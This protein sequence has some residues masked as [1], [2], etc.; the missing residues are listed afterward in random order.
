MN[1]GACEL[2]SGAHG[3]GRS[4][5]RLEGAQDSC[6]KA[7]SPQNDKTLKTMPGACDGGSVAHDDRHARPIAL[8]HHEALDRAVR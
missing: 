4:P 2:D 6:D 7:S 8:R 1:Q 5:R 3:I